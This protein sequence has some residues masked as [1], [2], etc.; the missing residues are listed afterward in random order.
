MGQY[1]NDRAKKVIASK[2]CLDTPLQVGGMENFLATLRRY[3]TDLTRRPHAVGGKPARK[4]RIDFI[5]GEVLTLPNHLKQ[6]LDKVAPR[7]I[8]LRVWARLAI[9]AATLSTDDLSQ[10][11][12]YPL[13]FYRALGLVWGDFRPSAKRD[14]KIEARLCARRLGT[15]Y[16]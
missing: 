9:A 1:G 6:T 8:D 11:A 4:I 14:Y 2:N 10:N 16:V 3:F 13:S 12:R 5:P 15:R 7:D